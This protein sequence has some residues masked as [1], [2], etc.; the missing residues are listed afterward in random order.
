M[1]FIRYRTKNVSAV[2]WISNAGY[3]KAKESIDA[4]LKRLQ[5]DYIDLPFLRNH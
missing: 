5:S 3:E 1:A 2:C 4:S